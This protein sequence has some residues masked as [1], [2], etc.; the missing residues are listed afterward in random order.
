[1]SSISSFTF[2]LKRF[3]NRYT[4]KYKKGVS[5]AATKT[6]NKKPLRSN[7]LKF[8]QG[9]IPNEHNKVKMVKVSTN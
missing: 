6:L 2:K 7:P 8:S 9:I 1:M 3:L 4:P 5:S